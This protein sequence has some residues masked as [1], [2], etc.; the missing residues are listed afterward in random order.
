MVT[1]NRYTFSTRNQQDGES[2]FDYINALQILADKC[3]FQGF[4]EEAL[5]DRLIAGILKTRQ[6]L[7]AMVNPTYT[8]K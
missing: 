3:Q 1:A 7:L 5:R 2:S 4:L 8:R 6:R